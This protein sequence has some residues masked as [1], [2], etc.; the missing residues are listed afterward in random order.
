M[1]SVSLARPRDTSRGLTLL[2]LAGHVAL[3][4]IA[5]RT[6][7]GHLVGD[8]I[9]RFR[10]IAAHPGIP[11]RDFPVEYPP[12]DTAVIRVFLATDIRAGAVRLAIIS[13]PCHLGTF[14]VLDRFW[15]AS[16]GRW[17]LGLSLPLQIFLPFRLDPF[18]VLLAVGGASLARTGRERGGS[19]VLGMACLSKLW[20]LAVVPGVVAGG[21]RRALIWCVGT[22]AAVCLVW[23]GI[24]GMAGPNQVEGFRGAAG[25][26]IESSVGSLVWVATDEPT[27]YESG[28]LRVGLSVGWERTAL[29]IVTAMGVVGVWW[30]AR[31]WTGDMVGLPSLAAVAVVLIFAPVFSPQYVLWLLPWAAV[32]LVEKRRAWVAWLTGGASVLAATSLPVYWAGF[33]GPGFLQTISLIRVV[34]VVG[35]MAIYLAEVHSSRAMKDLSERRSAA[36]A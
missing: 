30:S 31:K 27:R 1:S 25:W 22:V 18:G 10:E 20:P 29:G 32:A 7:E 26:Q 23:V 19:V 5:I 33:Q 14:L 36:M 11:F 12:V 16:A 4:L 21:R 24:S 8:S 35:L 3:W 15:G 9:V 6:I 13:I 2:L 34:C 28:A 17:Y